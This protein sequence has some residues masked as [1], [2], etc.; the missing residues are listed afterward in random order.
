M[1]ARPLRATPS[2]PR[3]TLWTYTTSGDTNVRPA[4]NDPEL[5]S[6]LAQTGRSTGTA[7]PPFKCAFS[8]R[9]EK[10]LAVREQTAMPPPV[11]ELLHYRAAIQ[12]D[13]GLTFRN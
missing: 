8:Q 10:P 1:R 7:Q 4:Q 5:T 13:A 6:H 9:N 3:R 12:C 2:A 11:A